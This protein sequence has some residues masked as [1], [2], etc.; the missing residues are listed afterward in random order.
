[1]FKTAALTL[2]LVSAAAS[3]SAYAPVRVVSLDS[4]L[5]GVTSAHTVTVTAFTLYPHGRMARALRGAAQHHARTILELD[6]EAFGYARRENAQLPSA[7]PGVAILQ[8]HGPLH[9]KAALLDGHLYLADRNWAPGALVVADDR[10]ADRELV[11]STLRGHAGCVATF[12]T[13]KSDALSQEARLIEAGRGDLFVQSESFGAGNPVYA[14]IERRAAEGDRVFLLV[15]RLEI[16]HER[17]ALTALP[18]TVQI[19]VTHDSD[20]LAI[21]DG[22]AA[23][24]GST[25]ATAGVPEQTDWGMTTTDRGIVLTLYRRFTDDWNAAAPYVR[26]G[27]NW[28]AWL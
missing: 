25:N 15:S 5:A 16:S 8:S 12:C 18:N 28:T 27:Q 7:L 26:S 3:T 2:L 22:S 1:M 4:V 6:S 24:L 20:K 19:R 13:R 21:T 10:P 17:R 14:A 9:L 11:A 23:W